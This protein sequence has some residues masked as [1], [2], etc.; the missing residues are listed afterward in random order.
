M[1]TAVPKARKVAPVPTLRFQGD[2]LAGL[3][4]Q[5]DR[6]TATL[7]R[8]ADNAYVVN[9]P[10]VSRLHA[11]LSRSGSTMLLTDLGS[12]TGTTL[13][14]Q[15]LTGPTVLRH[16]DRVGFGQASA[17]FEDPSAVEAEDPTLV[18]AVPEIETGPHLSPRQQQV[19]ALV[20]DG[21]TNAEIGDQL[22]ITERT[23]KAYAQELYDKLGVRNRAGAV[24]QAWQHGLLDDEL[25]AHGGPALPARPPA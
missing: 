9:H 25:G 13:N 3:V 7:G 12:S 14:D 22:G 18:F 21:L 2:P 11:E 1:D 15:A 4:V 10:G 20:A 5:I 19:I 23:V 8:Q 24:S 17:T 6:E 16:G